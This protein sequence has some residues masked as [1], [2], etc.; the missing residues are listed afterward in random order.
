MQNNSIDRL[1]NERMNL[2]GQISSKERKIQQLESID[3]EK[4]SQINQLKTLLI[5]M[6]KQQTELIH[7]IEQS[8][9]TFDKKQDETDDKDNKIIN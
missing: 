2:S 5:G 4:E 1:H 8:K 7:K 6:E 9:K 3:I